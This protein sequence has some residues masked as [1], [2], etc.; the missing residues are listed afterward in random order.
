ML[1]D[2]PDVEMIDGSEEQYLDLEYGAIL[3]KE[4]VGNI[5]YYDLLSPSLACCDGEVCEILEETAEYIEL[6]Q[7]DEQETD[8]PVKFKLSRRDFDVCMY[9]KENDL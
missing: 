1:V 3:R 2:T 6:R 8:E 9:C 7:I 4:T 5:D